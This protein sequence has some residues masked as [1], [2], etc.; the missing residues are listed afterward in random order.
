VP[1]LLHTQLIPKHNHSQINPKPATSKNCYNY[2]MGINP[3]GWKSQARQ[4]SARADPPIM[5]IVKTSQKPINKVYRLENFF[6]TAK[7]S[8]SAF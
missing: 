4:K 2:P 3:H 5:E 8:S 1:D 6:A 7:S